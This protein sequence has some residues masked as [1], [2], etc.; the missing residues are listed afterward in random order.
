MA[1]AALPFPSRKWYRTEHAQEVEKVLQDLKAS[2]K[3]SSI[4]L[5]E[6]ASKI[7]FNVLNKLC[8]IMNIHCPF[9][10]DFRMMGDYMGLDKIIIESAGQGTNPTKNLLQQF[11]SRFGGTIGHVMAIL[12][13]INRNDAFSVLESYCQK[14]GSS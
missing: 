11:D 8:P 6:K 4:R 3:F 7:P 13:I 1:P 12:D 10:D 9:F 2:S 5:S 14:R